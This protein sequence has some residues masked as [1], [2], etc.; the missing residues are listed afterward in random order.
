MATA[1]LDASWRDWL[2]T[3]LD[4]GCD[5]VELL[6]ILI[7]SGFSLPAISEA[8]GRDFPPHILGGAAPD[9]AALVDVPAQRLL[10]CPDARCVESERAQIFVIETFL[11]SG[12]CDRL[13]DMTAQGLRPSTVTVQSADKAFR[14]SATCDLGEFDDPLVRAIDAKIARA[15]GLTVAHSETMQAQRYEPGQEFK[16]HTDYFEPGTE[17]Y[18]RF[19]GRTGNRTWTFTLYLEAPEEGGHTAFLRLNQRFA[20]K[21][22]L[23]VVWNNLRRDGSP[24]PDTLHAGEPVLRGRKTIITKWFREYGPGPMFDDASFEKD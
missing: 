23:A 9:Y 11:E 8:M 24:N 22:G 12:A 3:N 20:P 7:K 19:A 17:E 10:A 2:K 4:R 1:G 13:V 14:T 6:N 16:A 18:Q 5:R 15:L 21:K